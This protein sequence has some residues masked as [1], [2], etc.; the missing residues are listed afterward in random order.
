MLKRQREENQRIVVRG[1]EPQVRS[2]D[3]SLVF[4]RFGRIE[5]IKFL[6][7]KACLVSFENAD[8]ACSALRL[9]QS[10]QPFLH[11]SLVKVTLDAKPL[12]TKKQKR[13]PGTFVVVSS[14]RSKNLLI[15]VLP[16]FLYSAT[17]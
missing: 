2:E 9:D 6:S 14:P 15:P 3:L 10:L 5:N 8:S 17:N 16:S 12:A 11:N 13:L 4:S 1:L 7:R